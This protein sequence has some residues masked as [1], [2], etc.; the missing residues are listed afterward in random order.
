MIDLSDKIRI[1]RILKKHGVQGQV[2]LESDLLADYEEMRPELVFIIIDGKPV[3]FFLDECRDK[4]A[5]TFIIGLEF[6]KSK[7]EAEE[8]IGCE[9]FT[10]MDKRFSQ[11]SNSSFQYLGYEVFT[12]DKL[13]VGLIKNLETPDINPLFKVERENGEMILIPAHP[14]MIV[15][16]NKRKKRL[17][18][19]LPDGFDEI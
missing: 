7:E 5:N 3:P 19:K 9:V 12:S 15:S 11:Q 1:G 14:D 13:K 10:T 2:I 6:I 18:I 4:T 16:A 17:V 8:I